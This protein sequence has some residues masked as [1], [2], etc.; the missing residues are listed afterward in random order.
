MWNE[1]ALPA[2][3]YTYTLLDTREVYLNEMGHYGFRTGLC[4]SLQE[5][6]S[7]TFFSGPGGLSSIQS[8]GAEI[9]RRGLKMTTTVARTF[10]FSPGEYIRTI[11]MIREKLH[12]I[13][14]QLMDWG[15]HLLV[16]RTPFPGDQRCI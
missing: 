13:M 4:L 2:R 12:P 5:L 10:F 15:P 6:R 16:S 9:Q 3:G 1:D 8:Q 7:L 11:W 14:H